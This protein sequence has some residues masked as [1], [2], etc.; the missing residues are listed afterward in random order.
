MSNLRT[1]TI[2]DARGRSP[3]CG[4]VAP[5]LVRRRSR[6]S[7]PRLPL[8]TP[9]GP[10]TK[11]AAKTLPPTDPSPA[12]SP[13]EWS[14]AIF[15]RLPQAGASVPPESPRYHARFNLVVGG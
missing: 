7:L 11:G 2:L 15:S 9:T 5:S 1:W 10:L 6:G 14:G 12:P 8:I 13:Q 4:Q 3:L